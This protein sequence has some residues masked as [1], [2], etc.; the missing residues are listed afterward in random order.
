M[1][2]TI[3]ISI[4]LFVSFFYS[5]NNW[6]DLLELR[7]DTSNKDLFEICQSKP[8]IS[9]FTNV[10]QKTGYDKLL[11]NENSI[12]VFAPTNDAL[13]DLNIDNVEEM[14][15]W[16]MD[17]IAYL[18]YFIKADST[19]ETESVRMI[20][21]KNIPV[22]KNT[23]S[24]A[25]II[26]HNLTGKNGIV[27]ILEASILPR[28]NIWEYLKEQ[29][30]YNQVSYIQSEFREVMD[31]EKSIQTGVD[32]HGKP[33][34]DTIWT[35]QNDFLSNYP[36]DNENLN[37]T[38]LLI[39]NAAF[40]ILK[41]KYKKYFFQKD[42][43]KMEK[44]IL[45]QITGDLVLSSVKITESGRFPSTKNVLVDIDFANIKESYQASNGMVYKVSAAD[46]KIYQNKI[47]EQIIDANDYV[48]RYPQDPW[49]ERYRSWAKGGND[50]L[51]KGVTVFTHNFTRRLFAINGTD[52]L[53][54]VSQSSGS[55]RYDGDNR[56]NAINCYL[57]YEPTLYST[58][59][60]IAWN[61]YDD[62][63]SHLVGMRIDLGYNDAKVRIYDTIPVA[64]HQK[65][66]LSFPG[67]SV[68]KRTA[69]G[70]IANNFSAFTCM[71]GIDSAGINR[72]TILKRFK[73]SVNETEATSYFVL[74]TPATLLT[75]VDAFGLGSQIIC[76]TYGKATFLV[77]NT[78]TRTSYPGLMFLNYLKIK[79][80]VDPND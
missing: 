76:P 18:Q 54:D 69:D 70:Y 59:Y 38:V 4:L 34:Y 61:A 62:V 51:L 71:G 45:N 36:V 80:I 46:I 31:T 79:P 23:I 52:S 20:N 66:M 32:I 58:S 30:D 72:E 75:E 44:E 6:D 7:N 14:K 43:V 13:K 10:L 29:S 74:G 55:I 65:L 56:T 16:I 21:N 73:K 3:K 67:E 60:E 24:C 53:V 33:I 8:E 78:F 17:Y 57:K 15:V 5:C 39:D 9:I 63:S 47:K 22:G 42:V 49:L 40:D 2:L 11:Q 19:F 12:T 50:I 41:N 25:T 26:N 48:E 68:V 37:F 77:T 1:K 27:H 28:K 64:I 35:A